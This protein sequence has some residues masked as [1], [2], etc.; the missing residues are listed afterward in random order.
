M[1]HT[2][3]QRYARWL[4]DPDS[5]GVAPEETA[6]LTR[7]ER[8]PSWPLVQ[9][10]AS[11]GVIAGAVGVLVGASMRAVAKAAFVDFADRHRT[12]VDGLSSALMMTG[13]QLEVTYDAGFDP[14]RGSV[15]C[16]NHISMLDGLLAA[17]VIPQPFCGLME[18]WHFKIPGYGWLM[19]L[20]KSIPVY[21]RE[22]GRTAEITAAA[23]Q[24]VAEGISILVFPEAHRTRDGH[25]RP[26]RRGTLFMARDAGIPVV[27]LAVRG[28]YDVNHRGEWQFDPGPVQVYVGPQLETAGMD[29]EAVGELA[30]R[31]TAFTDG[32]VRFGTADVRALR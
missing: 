11:A 14:V 8:H 4:Q 30:A 7:L 18:A 13:A 29:D 26:Y 16:Q 1:I 3:A 27:P 2:G 12:I 15:F 19:Q 10:A 31:L 22:S 28:L 20:G 21:P 23:R 6:L 5:L 17:A 9:P 24:R 32:W 25:V